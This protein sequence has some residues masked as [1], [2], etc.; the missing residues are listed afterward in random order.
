MDSFTEALGLEP[1]KLAASRRVLSEYG[2]M[3]IEVMALH[4]CNGKSD[5]KTEE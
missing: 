3:T 2:N 5:S 1:G 4:A